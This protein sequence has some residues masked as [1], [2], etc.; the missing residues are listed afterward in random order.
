MDYGRRR[1]WS[2]TSGSWGNFP[3]KSNI[4]VVF[5]WIKGAWKEKYRLGRD[6]TWVTREETNQRMIEMGINGYTARSRD[7]ENM[8]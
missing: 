7:R 1:P 2:I 5:K 6:E 4:F 3:K 8:I